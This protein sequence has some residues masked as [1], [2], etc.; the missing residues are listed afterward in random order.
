L[1]PEWK[2]VWKVREMD[3]WQLIGLKKTL[4]VEQAAQLWTRTRRDGV[5]KAAEGVIKE[6]IEAGPQHGG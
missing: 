3:M 2:D 4:T 1:V 6:A 5:A